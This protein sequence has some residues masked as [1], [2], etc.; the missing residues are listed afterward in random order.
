MTNTI[1]GDVTQRTM[2]AK[3]RTTSDLKALAFLER[4]AVMVAAK[5]EE[6][7]ESALVDLEIVRVREVERKLRE[8][9]EAKAAE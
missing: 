5:I 2:S 1:R 3:R 9:A 4:E 6:D 8:E 7:A